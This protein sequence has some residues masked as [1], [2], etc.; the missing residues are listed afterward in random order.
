LKSTT[1]IGRSGE[2]EAIMFLISNGFNIEVTN[3]RTG[4][5]EIDIIASKENLLVFV[6]VKKRK[7]NDYGY[8][9]DFLSKSQQ[10][11]IL[12]AA[13]NYIFDQN[14]EGNIRFDIISI[15]QD[16]IHHLED[17]FY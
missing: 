8:P 10:S 9:E 1:S 7:N 16:G 15:D 3:Y 5:S 11:R 2:D 6:E 12:S 13:E 4:R 17:A 14:W